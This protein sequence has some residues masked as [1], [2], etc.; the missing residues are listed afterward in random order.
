MVLWA[1]VDTRDK[2]RRLC[3]VADTPQEL[4]DMMHIKVSTIYECVSKAK[5]GLAQERYIRIEIPD[6]MEE[7]QNLIDAVDL[8]GDYNCKVPKEDWLA[9]Q[10]AVMKKETEG[11]KKV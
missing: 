6:D 11:R 7:T 9:Y 4:A 5:K 10:V 2:Y 8:A 3:T 1:A